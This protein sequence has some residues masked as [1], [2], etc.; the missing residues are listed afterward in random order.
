MH[1]PNQEPRLSLAL[2]KSICILDQEY[3]TSKNGTDKTEDVT[4]LPSH[5]KNNTEHFS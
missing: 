2:Q 1:Q 3:S 5:T 4:P